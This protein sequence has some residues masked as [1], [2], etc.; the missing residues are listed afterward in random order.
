MNAVMGLTLVYLVV[1]VASAEFSSDITASLSALAVFSLQGIVLYFLILNTVRT[2]VLLRRCLWA[3]VLAGVLLGTLSFIQRV[4]HSYKKDYAGFAV[5]HG[6]DELSDTTPSAESPEDQDYAAL[7]PSWRALGSL[8]DPNYYAQIMI[9]LV[10]IALLRLWISPGWRART[11]ALLALAAI[12]CGV[13]LSYSRGASIGL[14]A[15]VAA[16][17]AFRYLRMRYVVPIVVAVIMIVAITDPMFIRRVQT[18]GGEGQNPRAVDRSIL[19]RKTY[20][21]A[22]GHIFLDHP[23]LG[24]GFGQ[25]SKY[26]PRYGRMYGY[27]QPPHDAAAHNMYLQILAETGIMGFGAF[28][29]ILW[30]TVRPMFALRSYWARSR[31][32][33]AHTLAS[34]ML[35]LLAFLVTSIFLHLSFTRYFYLLLGLCGA[36]TAIYTPQAE[37]PAKAPLKPSRTYPGAAWYEA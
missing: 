10:P 21:I 7:Y 16:L 5:T 11:L 9:V 35:G 14:G 25:S 23:L 6:F 17:I 27:T 29:L 3:M 31:P 18:L 8:G 4:T 33:Y 15:L 20:L 13:V 12:L 30:A 32:E 2:P 36:A 37:L 26:I 19:L 1:Q 28:L 22:G 24:V 34:L